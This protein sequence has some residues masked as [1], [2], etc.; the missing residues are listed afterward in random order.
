VEDVRPE[1]GRGCAR[2]LIAST[3]RFTDFTGTQLAA[4]HIVRSCHAVIAAT[5]VLG[6]SKQRTETR[7]HALTEPVH[8]CRDELPLQPCRT[9]DEVEALLAGDLEIIAA[10]KTSGGFQKARVLTLRSVGPHSVVFRAKWR[11][12]STATT[13]NS[14]RFELAAYYVQ[15]LFLAPAEYVVP[16]TAPFCFPLAAYRERVDGTAPETFPRSGCVYGVLSFWLEDVTAV[17]DAN[18]AGWF[19]GLYYH[20]FDPYLFEHDRAYHD[21]IARVNLLTYVI[22]HRDSHAR[23][24]VIA[25][26]E[27]QPVV[28]TVYSVDNSKSF[29]LRQN[30]GIQPLHNWSAIHVPSLPRTAI[31]R[32][33]GADLS[34]LAMIAV[35]RSANGRLVATDVGTA[36]TVTGLDWTGDRLVVGLTAPEIDEVRTRIDDLLRRVDRAELALY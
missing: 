8:L 24:F 9:A 27:T 19:H 21:S 16:P 33:R 17:A 28:H 20:L 18:R 22:A 30:T 36:T 31:E 1:E 3:R 6:C 32:L 12:H 4:T 15:K 34:S 5:C 29:T 25:R 14:P 2:R 11:A 10:K 26:S 13:G 7:T 35:L 23:N